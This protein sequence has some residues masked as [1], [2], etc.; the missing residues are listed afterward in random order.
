MGRWMEIIDE[1]GKIYKEL[2]P[3][4][5][6]Y[7]TRA[8]PKNLRHHF[9]ILHRLDRDSKHYFDEI[10]EVSGNDLIQLKEEL[11]VIKKLINYEYFFEGL[12]VNSVKKYLISETETTNIESREYLDQ[13]IDLISETISQ[14]LKVVVML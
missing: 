6:L 9:P 5:L 13:M 7:S 1:N 2:P 14:Q 3:Y 8:F 12:D 4:F 11:I 10:Q